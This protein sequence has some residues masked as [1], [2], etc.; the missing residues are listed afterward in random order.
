MNALSALG[1]NYAF[2][3][4]LGKNDRDWSAENL[5]KAEEARAKV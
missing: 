1:A 5:K 4:M 3:N 2:D